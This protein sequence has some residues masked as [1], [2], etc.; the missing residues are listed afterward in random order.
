MEKL[1]KIQI[2]SKLL[3]RGDFC[4]FISV[5]HNLVLQYNEAR[6]FKFFKKNMGSADRILRIIIAAITGVLYSTG[7]ISIPSSIEN[8]S[9][10]K[11]LRFNQHDKFLSAL[12]SIWYS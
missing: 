11:C 4:H 6:I 12:C 7:T 3:P 5:K 2:E 10:C 1:I 9:T 8:F